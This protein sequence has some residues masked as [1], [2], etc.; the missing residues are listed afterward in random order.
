MSTSDRRP[1]PSSFSTEQQRWA[2]VLR[3]DPAADGVFCFSV[4]TTRIYAGH[5]SDAPSLGGRVSR[6]A[7]PADDPAGGTRALLRFAFGRCSLG[8]ILVAASTR[9]ICAIFLGDDP[10]VLERDLQDRFPHAQLIAGDA[11]VERWVA[12]V[13]GFVETPG[14]GLDLPLDIRGTAFQQRVWRALCDIPVGSTAN[15]TQIAVAIG[16]PTAARAVARACAA[17]L[18]AIAIPCHR[19]VRTNGTLSGYRWGVERKRALLDLEA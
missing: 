19:V 7:T 4:R 8:S 12:K 9:G 1:A 11:P 3:R 6:K 10:E 5:V 2:A 13:V 18:L 17:N 14:I 15:Y 16:A